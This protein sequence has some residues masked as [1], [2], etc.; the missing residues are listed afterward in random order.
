[1]TDAAIEH[2]HTQSEHR[3]AG[4]LMRDEPTEAQAK[5]PL[6]TILL[7]V[8]GFIGTCFCVLYLEVVKPLVKATV[9]NIE[10]QTETSKILADSNEKT[11]SAIK[12]LSETMQKLQQD[13]TAHQT[14]VLQEHREILRDIRDK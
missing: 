6:L 9:D 13:E 12:E 5:S 14:A 11:S 10:G 3:T 7:I 1:M 8:F 4:E 2:T